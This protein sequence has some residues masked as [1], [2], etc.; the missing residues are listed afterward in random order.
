[1]N[2]SIQK[3]RTKFIKTKKN[4]LNT[5][6]LNKYHR[7][8]K[9]HVIVDMSSVTGG[10]RRNFGAASDVTQCA[11]ISAQ[12]A[13]GVTQCAEISAQAAGKM[14]GKQQ[15]VGSSSAIAAGW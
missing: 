7:L 15:L 8:E 2:P 5:R 12:A 1:M 6:H 4:Q 9:I 13:S 3:V 10:L 11:E 14:I